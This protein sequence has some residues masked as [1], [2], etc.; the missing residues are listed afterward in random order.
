MQRTMLACVESVPKFRG[1]A[2]FRTFLFVIARRELYDFIQR[3]V[4]RFERE[5]PDLGVSS[6]LDLGL[7]PSMVVAVHE[8]E[9]LVAEAMRRIPVDYQV[10]LELFYWE[11]MRGPE[12]AEV[13]GIS[14][15]TVRTRLHRAR[16][17]LLEILSEHA[18]EL[19]FGPQDLEASVEALGRSRG[20]A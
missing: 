5:A 9:V 20:A 3:K 6:I 18:P 14:P 19:G 17:A 15:T 10:T 7:T 4:R 1:D 13:L 8:R 12:L 16:A 11:Q 2:S